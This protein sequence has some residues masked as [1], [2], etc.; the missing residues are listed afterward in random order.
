MGQG[1]QKIYGVQKLEFHGQGG[2]LLTV[3]GE[4]V[5]PEIPGNYGR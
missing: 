1:Q 4:I 2:P 5:L 3:I